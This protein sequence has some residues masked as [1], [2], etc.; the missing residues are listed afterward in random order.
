MYFNKYIKKNKF[1]NFILFK[2][3]NININHKLYWI[4]DNVYCNRTIILINFY[5]YYNILK[6]I[7]TPSLWQK[8]QGKPGT[9]QMNDNDEPK[10]G[11]G[12]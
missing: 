12:C 3:I 5:S 2:D 10:G 4:F 9:I 11:C 8:Q 1:L 7:E 6:I